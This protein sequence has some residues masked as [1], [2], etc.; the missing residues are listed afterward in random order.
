MRP[1][2]HHGKA[3]RNGAKRLKMALKAIERLR[4]H[5]GQPTAEEHI[6]RLHAERE[7]SPFMRP[8]G[9]GNSDTRGLKA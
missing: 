9:I 7:A 4:I 8:K 3:N 5:V 2:N 1:I 6:A